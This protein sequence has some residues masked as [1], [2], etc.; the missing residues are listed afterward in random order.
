MGW[1]RRYKLKRLLKR[2][3]NP[4][5]K[6]DISTWSFR[7]FMVNE[8]AVNAALK[9]DPYYQE[10]GKLASEATQENIKVVRYNISD[11]S[12]KRLNGGVSMND[13]D[14][15]SWSETMALKEL[16]SDYDNRHAISIMNAF[17]EYIVVCGYK[18]L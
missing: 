7:I 3:W 12:L 1:L 4:T 6:F 8:D 14:Y 13:A 10:L 15:I 18:Y 9:S 2:E 11:T 17:I 16:I 5:V